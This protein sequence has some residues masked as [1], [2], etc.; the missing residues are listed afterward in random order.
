MNNSK[1]CSLKQQNQTENLLFYSRLYKNL[2]K[3]MPC[4]SRSEATE[5][6]DVENVERAALSADVVVPLHRAISGLR[7]KQFS[8]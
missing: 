2:L 7:A 8:F 4:E 6:C 1:T 5:G 3:V